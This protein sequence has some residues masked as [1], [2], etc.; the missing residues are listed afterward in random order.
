MLLLQD[1]HR[2]DELRTDH[3]QPFDIWIKHIGKFIGPIN[4]GCRIVTLTD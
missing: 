4:A 3:P 1:R 2:D